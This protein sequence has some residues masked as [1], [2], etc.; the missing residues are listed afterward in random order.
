MFLSLKLALFKKNDEGEALAKFPKE[1][2]QN[3]ET[4]AKFYR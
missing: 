2:D 3:N 4:Q 1:Y